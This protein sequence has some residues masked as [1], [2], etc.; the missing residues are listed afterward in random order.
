M[1]LL[2][3]VFHAAQPTHSSACCHLDGRQRPYLPSSTASS[4]PAFV[5]DRVGL[6]RLYGSHGACVGYS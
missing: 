4:D 6:D 2:S 3:E 1:L 5:E